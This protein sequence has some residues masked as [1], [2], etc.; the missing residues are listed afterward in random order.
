MYDRPSLPSQPRADRLVV[1]ISDLEI[2]AGG[3]YDDVP[4]ASF[5][6][7]VVRSYS[8][9]PFRDI[10]VDLVLNGDTF[11]LL[12]TSVDGAY[13]VHITA[14]VAVYKL[15]RVLDAHPEF[16][17]AVRAFL[18][19]PAPRRVFFTVGNHDQELLVPEV[20]RYL[21]DRFDDNPGIY[22][23]G[24][25]IGI[26]DALFEHGSQG[27]TLFRV[28]PGP[29]MVDY[30]GKQILRLPWGSVA[31]LQATM[32]LQPQLYW[33]DRL[34]PR[35][36]IFQILPEL[37]E[38]LVDAFWVYWT[39][40]YWR[41]L[42]GGDPLKRV[43]W[44]MVREVAYR[45][46]SMDPDVSFGHAYGDLLRDDPR[47]RVR[48]IGHHHQPTWW[49]YGDRKLLATGCYRNEFM[50]RPDGTVGEQL[51][52]VH[53]EVYQLRGR[54]VRSHLVELSGPPTPEGFVPRDLQSMRPMVRSLLKSDAERAASLDAQELQEAAEARGKR[55]DPA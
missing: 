3:P 19:V 54:T 18:V 37:R 39:R 38:V 21:R 20:Q 40:D 14:E 45:F 9:P 50:V 48:S 55:R 27:D 15:R 42:V 2:G 31:L 46:G 30:H 12:K 24:F 7:S 13:P 17:D 5:F 4:D 8:R 26:G 33:A 29:P 35:K 52:K 47:W 28:P 1:A 10:A 36:L 32:P 6:A 11:D 23:P 53:A 49:S 25:G 44:T 22:L 16:I 51:P 34:K 43:S 41:D